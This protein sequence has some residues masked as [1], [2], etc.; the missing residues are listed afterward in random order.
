MVINQEFG[1]LV[2]R[3]EVDCVTSQKINIRKRANNQRNLV[4]NLRTIK[5]KKWVSFF[6]FLKLQKI[7]N[8]RLVCGEKEGFV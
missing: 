7:G 2:V 8:K 3:V 6:F 1:M 4:Q 5:E